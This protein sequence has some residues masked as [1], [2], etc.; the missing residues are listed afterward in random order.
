MD[1]VGKIISGYT[2]KRQLG[3][4]GMA[5]VWYAENN[6]GAKAAIKI[7]LPNMCYD[8]NVKS[9]FLTEAMVTVKLNNQYIRK[10]YDYG[11]IDG[12]PAIVQE[13]LEGCDLAAMLKRGQRFSNAYLEKWWNQLVSALRLTHSL[14]IVHRDIKPANI[15]IDTQGN[16]KLM[17]FGI[18]KVRSSISATSTGQVMGTL[19]YM[20][21]EQV[22]D[23]KHID[24]R[25]DIYSLA[26]T[27]VHLITGEKPYSFC[28]SSFDMQVSIVSKPLDLSGLPSSW[29]T[30]LTPYLAKDPQMRPPLKT[31]GSAPV[32]NIRNVETVVDNNKNYART[33]IAAKKSKKKGG[34]GIAVF[35]ILIILG[36]FAA[37]VWFNW[38]YFSGLVGVRNSSVSTKETHEPQQDE[39]RLDR[40][41][42]S[43]ERH[44]RELHEERERHEQE[45]QEERDRHEREL[46]EERERLE[47]ELQEQL[48]KEQNLKEEILQ[49]Q[50]AQ[51]YNTG[52]SQSSSNQTAPQRT[53]TNKIN[54]HEYVDLGLPSGTLWAKCNVGASSPEEYGYYFAWGETT[55]KYNYTSDTYAYYSNPT[56]LPLHADAASYSWGGGW[57]MPTKSDFEELK[58]ECT[59]V[60]TRI[61]NTNGYKVSKNG[62]S[63]FLPAAGN[64]LETNRDYAGKYCLYWFSTGSKNTNLAWYFEGCY[65]NVRMNCG[66]RYLGLTVRPV[67]RKH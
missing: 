46:Q 31:F 52:T 33:K 38:D 43:L 29:R 9:R 27:F 36:I 63:I 7:L 11:K 47:K 59:W 2:L 13:Y 54:G 64:R 66:N 65:S 32:V 28:D 25:S 20:S 23:S 44:E 34:C 22:R 24:Y 50:Q 5:E 60:W 62:K 56:T 8:E 4:G 12:R 18:A 17:D 26:V 57:H 40:E 58:N 3:V 55:Y 42:Q 35:I 1:L 16:V 53:A 15:F 41:R 51:R 14:G 21:P 67:C 6:V 37:V 61:G 45:L 39:S 19:L 30:F 10:V 49:Q 48:I